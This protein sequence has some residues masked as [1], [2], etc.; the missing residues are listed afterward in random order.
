MQT[1]N[2]AKQKAHVEQLLENVSNAHKRG[3]IKKRDYWMDRY[4]ES[5]DAKL[6]AVQRV[7]SGRKT[8]N[9]LDQ[10]TIGKVAAGLDPRKGTDEIVVV[11]QKPKSSDPKSFRTYMAFGVKNKGLQYLVLRLLEQV[12]N[13]TPDQYTVRGGLHAAIMQVV[14]VMSTGPV[15]AV[16]LDVINCYPSFDGEKL[17]HLLPVPK[18]V[19]ERVLISA[20]LNM[21][22]GNIKEAK[23]IGVKEMKNIKDTKDVNVSH[24]VGPA[25]TCNPQGVEEVFAAARRGIPQGSATSSLIAEMM[26]AIALRKV[27]DVG[28]V[29]GYGDN[30]LLM[31]KEEGFVVTMLKALE[32]ALKAH[33]VGLLTPKLKTF[34]PGS[35]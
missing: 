20:H 27:P 33:P 8:K 10:R 11:H 28:N 17:A 15:W 3:Q 21:K 19:S 30:T 34:A 32:A 18:E 1:M 22:G 16:E 5:H 26:M 31:A 12:A 9:H 6:I 7:N 35:R 2:T 23:T 13:V 25:S 24:P 29:V 14:K 4:L